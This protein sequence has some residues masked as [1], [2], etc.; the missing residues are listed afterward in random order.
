MRF[1][2]SAKRICGSKQQAADGNLRHLWADRFDRAAQLV[3]CFYLIN[4]IFALQRMMSPLS[5]NHSKTF[6]PLWPIAFLGGQSPELVR[7]F[8]SVA[9]VV[10]AILVC[11]LPFIR[12]NR[13]VACVGLLFYA[14]YFS[15]FGKIDHGFHM[16][17]WTSFFLIFLPAGEVDSIRRSRLRRHEFLN[18]IWAAQCAILLF[19]TM[20]G[21]WKLLYLPYHFVCS[22]VSSLNPNALSWQIAAVVTTKTELPPLSDF[23]IHHPIISYP[24][25]LGALYIETFAIVVAFRPRL[26]RIWG[27]ALFGMHI[28]IKLSMGISFFY[29]TILLLILFVHSPF[30][31]SGT[32]LMMILEDMPLIG[33]VIRAERN[34]IEDSQPATKRADRG[35]LAATGSVVAS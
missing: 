2:L 12:A 14:A 8:V 15:S 35:L 18:V 26:H 29:T 19:Y 22:E 33:P 31:V 17:L 13:I 16:L 5:I 30:Q 20:A 34:A 7:T 21:V 10:S 28:G 9:W 25:Y 3:R 11:L 4:A 24:A 1:W 32:S 23:L 6:S 27:L